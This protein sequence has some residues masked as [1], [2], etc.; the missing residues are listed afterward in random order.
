MDTSKLQ[1]AQQHFDFFQTPSD[2]CQYIFDQCKSEIRLNVLDV[3]CGLG[4]LSKLFY[5]S[6]HQITLIE[7]NND[8]IPYLK[9]SFPNATIINKDFLSEE[10]NETY[11]IILCN[12]PF[13]T[14]SIKKIYKLFFVKLLSLLKNRTKLFFICPNMF[15]RSQHKIKLNLDLL[16]QPSLYRDFVKEYKIEPA[17]CY[18]NKYQ[19]IQLDSLDFTFD[20]QCVKKMKRI[21]INL[22]DNIQE[23]DKNI[24][25][26][27]ETYDIRFLRDITNF[28]KTKI[29]CIL[30][31]ISY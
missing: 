23:I 28:E 11:D 6:G 4:S 26:I 29:H 3:C 2:H 1:F 22:D 10:L 25:M 31:M 13:N 12:P 7:T 17:I 27:N 14:D 15:I 18:M 20:R 21:N 5:D 30:L 24:Y 9:T 8:F 16:K 19:F